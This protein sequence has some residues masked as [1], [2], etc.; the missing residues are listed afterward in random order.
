M[1][2]RGLARPIPAHDPERV[3]RDMSSD[4]SRVLANQ[5]TAESLDGIGALLELADDLA[6]GPKRSDEEQ[7]RID[8]ERMDNDEQRVRDEHERDRR[9]QD[10]ARLRDVWKGTALRRTQLSPGDS[11]GGRVCFPARAFAGIPARRSPRTTAITTLRATPMWTD[12]WVLLL[13][14]ADGPTESVFRYSISRD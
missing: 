7:L 1:L 13:R 5:R 3:L 14:L 4:E 2:P 8:R 10:L 12:E 6:N 9:L 11:T